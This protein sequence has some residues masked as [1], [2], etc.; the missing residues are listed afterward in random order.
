MSMV[1]EDEEKK[2]TVAL[3][4]ND[5]VKI[6]TLNS[7]VE[8]IVRNVDGKLVVE[9]ANKLHPEKKDESMIHPE[10]VKQ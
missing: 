3:C 8:I 1:Y 2:V 4:E 9:D 5:F 10:E 7:K 6:I